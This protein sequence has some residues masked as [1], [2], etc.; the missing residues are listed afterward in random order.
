MIAVPFIYFTF[1]ATYMIRKNG[2]VDL[3]AFIVMVYAF[4]AGCSIFVDMFNVYDINGVYEKTEISPLA[5]FTYCALIT[6]AVVPFQRLN[7]LQ[8]KQID[9]QKEWIVD[10]LSWVLILTFFLATYNTFT[11]LD[12]IMLSN[13]KDVRDD[14]YSNMDEVKLTGVERLLALPEALFSQF[15]PIALLLYF[16]NIANNRKSRLF[17]WLLLLA[18]LTP[19]IKAILIAGR[20]QPIYC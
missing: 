5:T 19:V 16:I 17:N 4:S 12:S 8:I 13:L 20:T 18:S 1:L 14:V 10:T 6:L 3:S 7:S 11:H 2:G 9:L 15:S